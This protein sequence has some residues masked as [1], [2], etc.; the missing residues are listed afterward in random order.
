MA[1]LKN[2]KTQENVHV[3]GGSWGHIIRNKNIT[4]KIRVSDENIK[5]IYFAGNIPMNHPKN[6][7]IF[8]MK[9]SQTLIYK[10]LRNRFPILAKVR[11]LSKK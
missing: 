8:C 7:Y 3:Y 4:S 9:F 6:V 1:C 5:H 10:L 11:L 2:N